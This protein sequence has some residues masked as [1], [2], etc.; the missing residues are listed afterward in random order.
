MKNK[1]KITIAATLLFA[2]SGF[3]SAKA[4]TAEEVLEV[5][6][7]VA[8]QVG[9]SLEI[10]SSVMVDHES[11]ITDLEQANPNLGGILHVVLRRR[12]S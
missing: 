5:I 10:I 1:F 2:L 11:R 4:I 9:Q 12:G 7:T 3:N 8:D 6:G